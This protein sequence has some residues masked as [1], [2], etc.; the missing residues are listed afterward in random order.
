MKK[1]AILSAGILPLPAVKGGAVETLIDIMSEN[2][3][4]GCYDFQLD[5]ISIYNEI[6]SKKSADY[7]KIR[8]HYIQPT[9]KRDRYC[10]IIRRVCRKFLAHDTM[11]LYNYLRK[12]RS[13]INQEKYDI[14]IIENRADYAT[15]LKNNTSAI[16]V[17]HL[18]NDYLSDGIFNAKS[19][20]RDSDVI[21]A[22]SDY[23]RNR[24]LDLGGSESKVYTVLNVIDVN[25]FTLTENDKRKAYA[26]REELG[27]KP[28]DIVCVYTG[29]LHKTKGIDKLIQSFDFIKNKNVKL[30]VVGGYFYASSMSDDFE[31]CL[32]TMTEKYKDRIYFTGYIDHEKIPYYC[33][34][35]DIAIVPSQWEEPAGLVVVEAEA[36]GL[37]LI[38]AKSGGIPEYIDENSAIVLQKG[39][40]FVKKLA[41]SIDRLSYSEALRRKIG[42][43]GIK[44]A[45]KFDK[46]HYL[47]N[48]LNCIKEYL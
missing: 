20:E 19:Y 24:V 35:A 3:Q 12:A 14:V 27:F 46:T 37:P 33:Y 4:F 40:S 18:H 25:K 11:Y 2:Y 22:V 42:Q 39:E 45:S 7:D 29:R 36:C 31:T 38:V 23:I 34:M 10:N 43:A 32:K 1:V 17:S 44:A 13:I 30:L 6:A 28:D 5:I 47:D 48:V 9:P 16:I 21:I 26:I 15:Y 41:E 8:Y